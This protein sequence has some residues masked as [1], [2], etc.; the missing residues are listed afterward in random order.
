MSLPI[1]P[2]NCAAV[3]ITNKDMKITWEHTW[4]YSVSPPC[5]RGYEIWRSVNGAA[6]SRVKIYISESEIY[7]NIREHHDTNIITNKYYNYKVR[8]LEEPSDPLS[9]MYSPYSNI[10]ATVYAPPATPGSITYVFQTSPDGIT[11]SGSY[12]DIASVPNSKYIR[13]VATLTCTAGGG[14]WTP[15]LDSLTVTYLKL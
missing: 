8:A 3:A 6:Y 1:A 13:I 11:Y 7:H 5:E 9:R 12:T 2:T 10:S 4:A 15:R 14:Q